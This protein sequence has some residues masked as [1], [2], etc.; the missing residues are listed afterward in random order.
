M[1]TLRRRCCLPEHKRRCERTSSARSEC[2]LQDFNSRARMLSTLPRRHQPSHEGL[3][4]FS[5]HVE[6]RRDS[7]SRAM[8]SLEMYRDTQAMFGTLF[9]WQSR[10][11][12]E[13]ITGTPLTESMWFGRVIQR[14]ACLTSSLDHF[15]LRRN[16]IPHISQEQKV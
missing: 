6:V 5:Q 11:G 15:A 8:C 16:L 7:Y 14:E 9:S 1:K 13:Q 12:L 4:Y 2:S 3:H 10:S